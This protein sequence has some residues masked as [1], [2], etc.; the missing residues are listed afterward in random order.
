[1]ISRLNNSVQMI[2]I[3]MISVVNSRSRGAIKFKQIV[4]NIESLGLKKPIVVASRNGRTGPLHYD[5]VCG[6]GRLEGFKALGQDTV[7]ALVIDATKED[8]LLMSLVENLARRRY[9]STDLAKEIKSMKERG[10]DY[11]EIARK[12]DL[13][14]SYVKGVIR[15][16]NSGEQRLL[17]AVDAG[18]IPISVAIIIASADDQAIQ[19]ALTEAYETEVLRGKALMRAKRLIEQ[20][21]ARTDRSKS[22]PK[23]NDLSLTK[24]MKVYETETARQSELVRKAKLCEDRLLFIVSALKS[25]F[26]DQHLVT[27]LRAESLTSLPAYLGERI[28]LNLNK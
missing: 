5:L 7:P 8:L 26:Q 6:Q 20:R 17:S 10:Y 24:L 27:L 3:S 19:K 18:H 25:I 1:M 13:D 28:N 12:T 16:L 11:G 22:R 14:V 9:R 23:E 2:P 4:E 21:R 15:L